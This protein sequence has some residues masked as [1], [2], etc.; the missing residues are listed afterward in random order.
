LNQNVRRKKVDKTS[1]LESLA[2]ADSDCRVFLCP[3]GS[4]VRQPVKMF[5]YW[6]K[7]QE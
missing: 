1:I 5:A 4:D 3:H 2:W 7:Y 6:N